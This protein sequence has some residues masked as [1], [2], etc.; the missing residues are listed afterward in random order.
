MT[1]SLVCYIPG[2]VCS[3]RMCE[4]F[5]VSKYFNLTDEFLFSTQ[6][7]HPLLV[8][9][10]CQQVQTKSETLVS[11]MTHPYLH[12]PF[13]S[14]LDCINCG[15]KWVTS[16]EMSSLL[17]FTVLYSLWSSVRGTLLSGLVKPAELKELRAFRRLQL[18]SKTAQ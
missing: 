3:V 17:Y 14:V 2:N 5:L 6:S 11:T 18:L 8:M 13:L 1:H 7:Q 15:E 12:H 10:E 4:I 9:S 16:R